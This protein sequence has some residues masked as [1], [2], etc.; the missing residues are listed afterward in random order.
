VYLREIED[1]MG[2][3]ERMLKELSATMEKLRR[4]HQDLH[5]STVRS[6]VHKLTGQGEQSMERE[7]EEEQYVYS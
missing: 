3:S 4:D 1:Q 7:S 5:G 2:K 6:L